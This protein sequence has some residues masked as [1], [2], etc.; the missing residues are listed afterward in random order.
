LPANDSAALLAEHNRAALIGAAGAPAKARA[1][2]DDLVPRMI[3]ALGPQH[4]LTLRARRQQLIMLARGG[5]AQEAIP[6]QQDLAEYWRKHAGEHSA[7]YAEALGDLA[8]SFGLLGRADEQ[9]HHQKLQQQ[10]AADVGQE[11]GWL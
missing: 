10:A 6:G 11:T 2:F 7:F 1:I 9:C 8:E 4:R 5:A 3:H